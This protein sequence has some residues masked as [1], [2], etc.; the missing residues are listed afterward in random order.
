MALVA[1][2]TK[3]LRTDLL[4]A[5]VQQPASS[6]C[7]EYSL[8]GVLLA[9]SGLWVLLS[10]ARGVAGWLVCCL[11]HGGVGGGRRAPT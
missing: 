8:C 1:T 2:G 11:G 4:L 5:P 7:V 10:E 3:L 9:V 6:A